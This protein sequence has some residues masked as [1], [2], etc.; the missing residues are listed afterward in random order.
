MSNRNK[1]MVPRSGGGNG[2][3]I[4]HM[5]MRS[6]FDEMDNIVAGFGMPR[7]DMSKLI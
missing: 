1:S 5:N 3:L 4:P 7:M 2:A 6:A